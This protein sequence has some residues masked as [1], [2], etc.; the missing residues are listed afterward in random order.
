MLDFSFALPKGFTGDWGTTERLVLEAFTLIPDKQSKQRLIQYLNSPYLVK[1][2]ENCLAVF[3]FLY[4]KVTNGNGKS[5]R[6]SSMLKAI[7]NDSN[8]EKGGRKLKKLIR[9]TCQEIV[10][11]SA[12][13]RL[14]ECPEEEA[15]LAT[16][17]IMHK[18]V[19]GLYQEVQSSWADLAGE[20]ELGTHG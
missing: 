2:G 20:L 12:Y 18:G 14:R 11:F 13:E 7:L 1:N 8:F 5:I 15:R 19:P 6:L 10:R 17:A 16:H 4:P 3:E 9:Q